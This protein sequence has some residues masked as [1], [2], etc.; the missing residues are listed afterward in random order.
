MNTEVNG[1]SFMLQQNFH[2]YNAFK[3]L[4]YDDN[5]AVTATTTITTMA[6]SL[7]QS[8]AS[9]YFLYYSLFATLIPVFPPNSIPYLLP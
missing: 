2:K 5:G 7:M 8:L 4:D 9:S 6:I 1:I 3:T